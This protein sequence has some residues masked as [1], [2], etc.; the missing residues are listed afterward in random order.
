VVQ[1]T[2]IARWIVRYRTR[3]RSMFFPVV[4]SKSTLRVE[5]T[6]RRQRVPS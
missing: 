2:D 5:L 1:I 4:K 3:R 6:G